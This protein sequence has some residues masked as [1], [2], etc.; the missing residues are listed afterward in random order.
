MMRTSVLLSLLLSAVL[1]TAQAASDH[2]PSG[3]VKAI[4]PQRYE[5]S[6]GDTPYRLSANF[7]LHIG[8]DRLHGLGA[9]RAIEA[10]SLLRYRAVPLSQGSG[11]AGE[12]REGWLLPQ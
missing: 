5:I 4:D 7:V 10:G 2:H 1:S 8:D 3:Q 12:I 6:I 9:V 11:Y